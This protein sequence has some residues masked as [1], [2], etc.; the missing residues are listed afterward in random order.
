MPLL[1]LFRVAFEALRVNLM[2]SILTMLG[3]II[4]VAAVIAM[5]T[6]GAGAQAEVDRQISSLGSNLFMVMSGARSRGGV[7]TAAG[8]EVRLTVD[9]AR[10][11]KAEIPEIVAAA[12]TMRGAGQVVL[13]NTN[14][15]TTIQ[16]ID[17]EY[18]VARGWQIDE[19]RDLEPQEVRTGG[20]VALLGAR[21]VREL[22]GAGNAIGQTIRIKNV[23][24]QVVGTMVPKGQSSMGYDQDDI[25]M[26]PL[27]A[28]RGRVLGRS[29]TRADSVSVIF[30]SV[31]EGWMMDDVE[32]Q[33]LEVLRQRHRVPPGRDDPFGIRNMSEIVETRAETQAVFNIL[34]AAVAS[35]SLVVG[36]IGIMN[37]MLV[38]VTERTREIGLR[39]AVGARARDILLQFLVEAVTL[40]LLGGFLGI[41]IALVLTFGIARIAEWPVLLEW[42]VVVLALGFSGAIGVF[43][44]YYPARKAAAKDPIDALRTE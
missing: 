34:L 12:P 5:V 42:P 8:S 31:A 15:A 7:R 3:I 32:R 9:D 1:E 41:V 40:C 25:V 27:R 16:G 22:F 21:V 14:W 35:V 37:I 26:I 33:I 13:G 17:N 29:G 44:G 19:G 10:A 4:G 2:R 20:K 18:L 6:V 23:P 11:L 43:F 24:F 36:G 38:S 39:M 28:A 30:V